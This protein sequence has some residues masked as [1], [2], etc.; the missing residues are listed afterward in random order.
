MIMIYLHVYQKEET[1]FSRVEKQR[2]SKHFSTSTKATIY[3]ASL[4]LRT[5][6]A[7]Y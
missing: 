4:K 1:I 3:N 7:K 6:Y 5:T 2:Q